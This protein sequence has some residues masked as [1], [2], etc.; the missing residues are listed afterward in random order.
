VLARD[1]LDAATVEVLEA[2]PVRGAGPATIAVSA[3]VSVDAVMRSLGLL[4]A[5]GFV[6]RCPRGWRIRR[7]R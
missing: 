3:G 1:A 4:A 6:E 7:H 2:V 5:G